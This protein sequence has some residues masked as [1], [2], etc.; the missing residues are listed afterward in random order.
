MT[1]KQLGLLF[2]IFVTNAVTGEREQ[3]EEPGQDGLLFCQPLKEGTS[4]TVR[5]MRTEQMPSET[6]LSILLRRGDEFTHLGMDVDF[7]IDSNGILE[8]PHNQFYCLMKTY[9]PHPR[10][11]LFQMSICFRKKAG[12]LR[13]QL[14]LAGDVIDGVF[15]AENDPAPWKVIL[16]EYGVVTHY[17]GVSPFFVGD[18]T[19]DMLKSL[20][21]RPAEVLWYLESGQFGQLK[22]V[23]KDGVAHRTLFHYNQVIDTNGTGYTSFRAGDT[24][25]PKYYIRTRNG[26]PR[27]QVIRLPSNE[28]GRRD[29]PVP[30]SR[31]FK[32][33]PFAGQLAKLKLDLATT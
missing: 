10:L 26:T 11:Y 9:G 20:E 1:L 2:H 14:L 8:W 33:N 6:E 12:Y 21:D 15:V 3:L 30:A 16:D 27:A 4:I 18:Y 25:F 32:H 28:H 23:G 5:G 29:T 22:V 13:E 17:K 24:L 19:E 7:A 31:D